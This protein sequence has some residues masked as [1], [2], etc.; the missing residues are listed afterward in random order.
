MKVLAVLSLALTLLVAPALSQAP[1]PQPP[2]ARVEYNIS[3]C[4]PNHFAFA[5]A[6]MNTDEKGV[7]TFFIATISPGPNQYV[8]QKNLIIFTVDQKEDLDGGAKQYHATGIFKDAD[9]KDVLADL[10]M[11]TLRDRFVGLLGVK[12]DIHY[13]FYGTIG[14]EE[15]MTNDSDTNIAFCSALSNVDKQDLAVMLV[16]WLHGAKVTTPKEDDDPRPQSVSLA[17]M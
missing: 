17:K 9:N 16:S 7:V 14:A 15:Y 2:S 5:H 11:F 10:H 4:K 1:A 8:Q 12:S 3:M 13:V 6:I